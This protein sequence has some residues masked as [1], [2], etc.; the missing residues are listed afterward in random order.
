MFNTADQTHLRY[1]LKN[2][3]RMERQSC[4]SIVF[5]PARA[6]RRKS[7]KKAYNIGPCNKQPPPW[8]RTT[9]RGVV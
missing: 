9:R 6:I 1:A 4:S 7:I 8:G 5:T 2:G 3:R